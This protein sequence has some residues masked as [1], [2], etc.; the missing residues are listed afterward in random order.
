MSEDI[1][2][3]LCECTNQAVKQSFW[4]HRK[5]EVLPPTGNSVVFLGT[6]GNPEATFTQQPQTAGFI[7]AAGGVRIYVD[8]GPG[9]V[10]RAQQMNFDL[11]TLDA[12]YI[13]HGHL[14]HYGGAEGVIEA[15]CWAM[16]AR[17]GQLLAP[18]NALDGEGIISYYH[19]GF[20]SYA[21]YQGGPQ[22][23]A[24]Q[25]QQ[26]V[27]LKDSRLIPIKA[28]HSDHNFGF[29]LETGKLTIGYT[30]DTNYIRKYSTP[31]GIVEVGKGHHKG[32]V[33]DMLDIVEY[34][35][36]IK[37]AFSQVDVL[38]ANVTTH[39]AW[40]HRHLTTLGLSHM[41]QN[42]KVKLCFLTHF[43]HICVEPVDIRGLMA[44]Y[45]EETTGVKSVVA[46]DGATH[47]LDRLL[48]YMGVTNEKA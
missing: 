11:G 39:N 41:L 5:R 8:P 38:I 17:R 22:V 6:G 20:S 37:Q 40:A 46:Y 21:G 47:D 45:I 7:I 2:R 32:P 43:N 28:Y 15:M 10:V 13:S 34:R 24:L 27:M 25:A 23:T 14:D 30:S 42:S 33:M 26:P 4:R 44:Q 48:E 9:A 19:Q 29:I 12:V 16:F 3:F 35:E 1:K 31:T 36:D 18:Q